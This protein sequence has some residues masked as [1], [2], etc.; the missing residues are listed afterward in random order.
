MKTNFLAY[1]TIRSMASTTAIQLPPLSRQSMTKLVDKAKRLGVEP[2]DYAKKLIEE[3]LAFEREA[4]K[5][6]FAEIMQPV[7]DATGSID[8][9]QIIKLVKMAKAEYHAVGRRKKR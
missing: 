7:R 1:G 8:D 4:E 5:S 3:G 2:A 6:S 9:A